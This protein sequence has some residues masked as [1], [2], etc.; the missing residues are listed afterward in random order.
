MTATIRPML[1]IH[2]AATALGITWRTLQRLAR[3]GEVPGAKVGGEWRFPHDIA[4]RMIDRERQATA[5][6][7]A[8]AKG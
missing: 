6:R 7:S 2:E 1:D 5:A 3:R 4:E 8:S